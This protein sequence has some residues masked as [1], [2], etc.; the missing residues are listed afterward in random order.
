MACSACVQIAGTL[1]GTSFGRKVPL[2][3]REKSS[4]RLSNPRNVWLAVAAAATS[5]R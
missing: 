4:V 1:Q 5:S 3:R 2:A